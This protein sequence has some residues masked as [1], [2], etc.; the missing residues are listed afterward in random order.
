M[1]RS[2]S[3]ALS[4]TGLALSIVIAGCSGVSRG[5]QAPPTITV[6]VTQSGSTVQAGGTVQLTATVTNDSTNKGVTWTVSCASS[7]CGRVSQTATASGVPTTYTAPPTPPTSDL[8]VTIAAASVSY[9]AVS[10]SATVTVSAVIVSA[11]PA[12][13]LLPLNTALQFTATV[14]NDPAKK[15]VSWM[16]TQGGTVCSPVCGTVVPTTTPS[17]S[18]TTYTAPAAVPVNPAV[19]LTATSVEDTSKA[20]TAAITVSAGTVELVPTR[21]DFGWQVATS[22]SPPRKVTLANTGKSALTITSITITG[23]DPGDFSQT[24]NCGTSVGAGNSCTL[25]LT[26]NPTAAGSRSADVTIT[27]SSVGSPQQVMLKGLGKSGGALA[28]LLPKSALATISTSTAPLPEGPDKVGSRVIHLIDSARR[29]PYVATGAKR[30]LLVR[31]WYPASLDQE[32]KPADYTSPKVWNYFSQLL[33][34]RLPEVTTNSCLDAP[35]TEG[36]HPVVVFSPGYTATFTD[37]T[38]LFEDLASRG[39]VVASV[40]HTYEATAVEFAD[41]RLVKSV[42]GS[43]LGGKLRGDNQ[44]L[45]FAT[46]VRLQDLRFVVDELQRLNGQANSPFAGRLDLARVAVMGHSMGGTTAFLAVERDARF[47]TGILIDANVPD[48]LIHATQTPVLILA[49]GSEQWSE[50]RCRLWGNLHGSRLAV[51]LQGAEH[52]TPSDAVWLARD[53]V[54]TGSMG[55]DRAMAAVRAYVAAF[56][57][58]NL[59]DRSSDPLLSGPSSDYPDAAVIMQTQSLCG[60]TLNKK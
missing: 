55:P 12:S 26:F 56:L 3:L 54:K 14:A 42:F 47:K 9:P 37:Y 29:D 36:I 33:G 25:T 45:T 4:L 19:T 27:D 57:D 1:K 40:D 16:L 5:T 10:S 51:N 49:M 50:D 41:G 39:Y 15:G 59:C 46:A 28:E 34:V 38:F 24:N 22:S 21:V 52:V 31:F 18:P 6:S 20:A 44:A 53:A 58:T 43:H 60:E 35:I 7:I 11:T 30:E 13:A 17:D 23:T 48:N 8:A 32:C 2:I